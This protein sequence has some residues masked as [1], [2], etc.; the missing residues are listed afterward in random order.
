MGVF[1]YESK[2]EV[3]FYAKSPSS[4]KSGRKRE[5]LVF[6]WKLRRDKKLGESIVLVE[7]KVKFGYKHCS[8]KIESRGG[9]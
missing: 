4:H 8:S 1:E 2:Y 7:I 6:L 5:S 3:D 9:G